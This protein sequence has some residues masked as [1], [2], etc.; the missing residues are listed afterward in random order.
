MGICIQ[1]NLK[2]FNPLKF[3]PTSDEVPLESPTTTKISLLDDRKLK[4]LIIKETDE[5]DSEK[6]IFHGF[7]NAF[8]TI[9]KGSFKKRLR[10]PTV[11]VKKI[12][13]YTLF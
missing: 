11:F 10:F 1:D 13:I 12:F 9:R 7:R 8:A 3:S 2:Y 5:T 6:Y 4:D